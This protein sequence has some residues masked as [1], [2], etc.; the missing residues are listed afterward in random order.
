M[1]SAS[2][3]LREDRMRRSSLQ[4][5]VEETGNLVGPVRRLPGL[6][7]PQSLPLRADEVIR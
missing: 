7:I 1:Q 6:P 4:P 5:G 2:M 3:G